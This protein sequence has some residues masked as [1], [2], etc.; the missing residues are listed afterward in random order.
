QPACDIESTL[1]TAATLLTNGRFVGVEVGAF[2]G[3]AA[4]FVGAATAVAIGVAVGAGAAQPTRNIV[5]TI[6]TRQTLRTMPPLLLLLAP[7]ARVF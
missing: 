3:V 1:E 5:P 4:A 2:V 7:Y 6:N